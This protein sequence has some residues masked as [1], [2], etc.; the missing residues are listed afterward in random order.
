MAT[1]TV[2][3]PSAL[4]DLVELVK[5]RIM[6][7]LLVTTL[8]A[9]VWAA[10][11]LPP[12]GVTLAGL[13]GMALTSGGASALNH[14]L[15]RDIDALMQRTR[16]RP[17]AAGRVR[18]AAATAFALA[19]VA[20]GTAVLAAG[21]TPLAALLGLSGAVL[22][23]G[24]YTMLLKRRTPQNIVIG[25]AAG[26]IPPLVG[27]AA[28]TGGVGAE[29]VLLFA[30]VFLW[31][32][33]HFWALAMLTRE[34]YERAGVPMLPVVASPRTTTRQIL[35]Y[36]AALV[37]AT[38]VPV[39]LGM[40]GPVFLAAALLLGARF[41]QLALRLHRD[42]TPAAARAT[43]L[44]SLAYLALVFAAIGVDLLAQRVV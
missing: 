40:L 20:A 2:A 3:G 8:A 25:G 4:A 26:A 6:A 43:F 41:V 35:A 11:G 9:M 16:R 24:L 22:Y 36:T 44:F 19:L 39:A 28:V 42:P 33:P 13:L 1:V 30:V 7:L 34:D 32:P 10:G 14:V 17:V 29:A 5:P 12:W 18:P 31:T 37:A 23:V 21:A 38:L 27:W 15:D